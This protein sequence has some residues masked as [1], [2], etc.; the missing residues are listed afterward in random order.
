VRWASIVED[1][2]CR[3]PSFNYDRGRLGHTMRPVPQQIPRRGWGG[4]RH[5]RRSRSG[6]ALPDRPQ[7]PPVMT[8]RDAKPLKVLIR[9]PRKNVDLDAL[10]KPIG[11][12][13]H[14][15]LFEPVRNL[16]HPGHRSPVGTCPSF[17]STATRSLYRLARNST[18]PCRDLRSLSWAVIRSPCP[19]GQGVG[20]AQRSPAPSLS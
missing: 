18:R 10:G 8:K 4:C 14:A 5:L 12:L 15:E 3:C 1:A 6:A 9:Q 20:M 16:L 19:R 2:R 17:W 11:V 13:G 7:H